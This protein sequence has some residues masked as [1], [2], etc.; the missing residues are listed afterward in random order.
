[1]KKIAVKKDDGTV[2][3]VIPTPEATPEL[4]ERD[5]KAVPGYVSHREIDDDQLPQDRTFRNAWTDDLDTITVDVHMP[6]AHEIYRDKLRYLRKAKLAALD[7]K[8]MQAL[9]NSESVSEISK[10]KQELRDITKIELPSTV[11]ELSNFL[12]DILKDES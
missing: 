8:F 3:I 7:I 12:P 10:K 4:M 2:A 11:E 6:K 1:M 9:E 5:A